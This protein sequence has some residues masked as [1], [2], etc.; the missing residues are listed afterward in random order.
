MLDDPEAVRRIVD[1]IFDAF[2]AGNAH[3]SDYRRPAPAVS[4]GV[5]VAGELIHSRGIGT[6]RVGERY[7]PD[8]DSVF[9][10]ASM[11]KSFTAMTILALRDDGQLRLDD[12]ISEYLPQT[13]SLRGPTRD[14]PPITIRHLLSM[15]SGLATDDPWGDRLQ[16]LDPD[17]FDAMLAE[18]KTFAW[19]T[20]VHYEYSNLGYAILGRL[21]TTLCD[22]PFW[23]AITRRV[24]APLRLDATG[25][26]ASDYPSQRLA[27][28]YVLVDDTWQSEPVQGLGAF[29]AMGGLFSS[30]ADLA[31][32]VAGFCDAWPPRDD[33]E[34]PHPLCRA[35]RREMQRGHTPIAMQVVRDD[36]GALEPIV[37]GYGFGLVTTEHRALGTTISHSGGYPGFG[38]HMRWHPDAQVGIVA[39]A[40]GR[41]AQAAHA[42]RDALWALVRAAG[43][44]DGPAQHPA[45][46]TVRRDVARLVND[47]DAAGVEAAY[48]LNVP[49]D[50]P[51]TRRR[52]EALAIADDAPFDDDGD[53][54]ARQAC[55]TRRWWLRSARSSVGV[56]AALNPEVPP[57]IQ[58]L[59]LTAIPEPAAALTDAA[60]A[61]TD[62]IN[63]GVPA[64]VAF[65][66]AAA[67]VA[68]ATLLRAAAVLFAP[69][70]L[71]RPVAADATSAS[72]LLGSRRG[73]VKV[74]IVVGDGTTGIV[75]VDAD[76]VDRVGDA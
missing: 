42:A 33:R 60:H 11:T 29:A 72:F 65:A 47:R 6:L 73:D 3:L 21:I 48:A 39:L 63:T 20:G 57:R 18:P 22:E 7:R 40:N 12:P 52:A 8:A 45:F 35:S 58:T 54:P 50:A 25:W 67:E 69:C 53:D 31:R 32:W 56:E 19:P 55:T 2:L 5:I 68:T 59:N 71:R 38:S 13:A 37:E 24:L 14:S 46:E 49:L 34:S 17:R 41:Y 9:R 4:Y 62:Q 43:T 44:P 16:D 30:V 10:I 66:D 70:S 28:G 76:P 27:S 36:A 23:D 74:T 51:L 15:Q 1:P 61:L 64:S 26:R 75:R